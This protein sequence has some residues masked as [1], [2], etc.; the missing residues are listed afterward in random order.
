MQKRDHT[1]LL[2]DLA[3]AYE[4]HAPNSKALNDRAK[5]SLVDGGSHAL[6][7]IE[8][9]PP[10]IVAAKGAWIQDEDGH[11]IL[12]FWQGHLGNILGHNPEIITSALSRASV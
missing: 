9:F 10:R 6:R 1:Q 8:P 5:K 2:G 4:R 3:A 7:L 12:D 11:D